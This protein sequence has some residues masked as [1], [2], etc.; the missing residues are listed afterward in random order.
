M[1]E[2][3]HGT[4]LCKADDEF[5][6]WVIRTSSGVQ[7]L[8]DHAARRLLR[9]NSNVYV[10]LTDYSNP[11]KTDTAYFPLLLE[12][13]R[14]GDLFLNLIKKDF[15][16]DP[17][18]LTIL[19]SGTLAARA[20][21]ALSRLNRAIATAAQDVSAQPG[22][23]NR[24]R[25]TKINRAFK[26]HEDAAPNCG[27]SAPSIDDTYIQYP[28]FPIGFWSLALHPSRLDQL[29]QGSDCIHPN[30]EGAQVY[31]NGSGSVSGVFDAA[32]ELLSVN[33]PMEIGQEFQAAQPV[34]ALATTSEGDC[35]TAHDN[36]GCAVDACQVCI[37][38]PDSFCCDTAWNSFCVEDAKSVCADA[39]QC[40]STPGPT[41]TPTPTATPGGDCTSVHSGP[42]CDT[43]P[44][45]ACVCATDPDCCTAPWDDLCVTDALGSCAPSCVSGVPSP[46]ATVLP[47]P[48][49]DCCAAHNGPGC[50]DDPCQSCVCDA[51]QACCANAWDQFCLNLAGDTCAT[52]CSCA[53]TQTP[54]TT[55]SSA[56]T[57]TPT[58]PPPTAT[59][60]GAPTATPGGDCCTAHG[61]PG[62]DVVECQ[63][64]VCGADSFCCAILWDDRCLVDAVNTCASGCSCAVPIL[65]VGDCSGGRS[66]T[67]D[68]ILTMVNIALG[69]AA[70]TTCEA[71]DA[72]HDGQITVDEIL[73]AV[74][75]AL[76]GC[77][78]NP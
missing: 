77:V 34:A 53:P 27:G 78:Q 51:D 74:N 1:T 60:T 52:S 12:E 54:T 71:G 17:G 37:C 47:T 59:S 61:G 18:C 57:S 11:F 20:Q 67:V 3:Q 42:G 25:F 21:W 69:N 13:A 66:V 32:L 76:N 39:C 35:C 24:V 55:P 45:Q 70:V 50:N 72:N 7:E 29:L 10:V 16:A 23:A 28:D 56:P 26:G 22:W 46:T 65:C 62:C 14:A 31:A 36:A 30:E 58:G 68:E 38:A 40:A 15:W 9:T 43:P 6:S 33:T 44:C 41:N 5:N 64:C 19:D 75:N 48:G 2:L 49:G 8:V 73:T 4:D 63:S